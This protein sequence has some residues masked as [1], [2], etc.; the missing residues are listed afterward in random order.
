MDFS[1]I[2]NFRYFFSD[3]GREEIKAEIRQYQQTHG[4]LW[5]KNFKADFPDLTFIIDLIANHNAPNAF[6]F[7]KEYIAGELDSTIESVFGR[8]AAK[9]AIFGFLEQNKPSVYQLHNE[10]KAEIDRKQF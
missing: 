1:Q 3:A 5:L 8:I 6:Y 9:G 7:L 2:E 10:L 4:K